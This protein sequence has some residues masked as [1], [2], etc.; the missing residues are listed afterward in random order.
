MD[1]LPIN[2][3]NYAQTPNFKAFS[4][5]ASRIVKS[6]LNKFIPFYNIE[7]A[8]SQGLDQFVSFRQMEELSATHPSFFILPEDI[9]GMTEKQ[10]S[11]PS[12]NMFE[13]LKNLLSR[14]KNVSEY[15]MNN[16][17][18]FIENTDSKYQPEAIQEVKDE[19]ITNMDGRELYIKTPSL[20]Y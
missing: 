10:V 4:T 5:D 13:Y 2:G 8:Y 11:D 12:S 3:Q 7:D 6:R 20:D 1:I 16:H 9:Q 18:R 15:K 19:L 14:S 17:L